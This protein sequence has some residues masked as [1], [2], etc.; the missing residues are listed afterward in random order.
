MSTHADLGMNRTGVATSPKLTAEMLKGQE[1]F[2]PDLVG[3][4]R[5]I[6]TTR[7]N[8]AREWDATL[9][10]VPPPLTPKGMVKAGLT[11]LKGESPTLLI[12]KLGARLGFERSGV[13]LYEAVLSKFDAYGSFSGG[14]SRADI[15]SILQDEF[16]HF[17]LLMDAL[18]ELGADPTVMT[19]SADLEATITQGSFAVLVDARTN[20]AQSLE[21]TLAIELIDNDCWTHLIALAEDAGQRE[22]GERFRQALVQEE[23][24][25]R[26]VRRWLAASDGLG[27]RDGTQSE[28]GTSAV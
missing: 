14:P 26:E 17:R 8:K 3:D 23:R 5:G 6:A 18:V 10:S 12:D 24:H 20:L 2:A 4:E 22:L 13:R 11:A 19:P 21:A 9:G 15:E 16:S 1:E 7:S 28:P 27:M 25:L